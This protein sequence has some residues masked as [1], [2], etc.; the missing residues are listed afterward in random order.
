MKRDGANFPIIRVEKP[1]YGP[2]IINYCFVDREYGRQIAEDFIDEA[3]IKNIWLSVK[4]KNEG[5]AP[6]QV[7][8]SFFY[9]IDDGP[10]Q[11]IHELAGDLLN[12]GEVRE[13]WFQNWS[14]SRSEAADLCRGRY[15]ITAAVALEGKYDT[16]NSILQNS[17]KIRI[18][19]YFQLK[20]ISLNSDVMIRSKPID[21]GEI[22]LIK[23]GDTVTL[24]TKIKNMGGQFSLKR[25]LPVCWY[26][27]DDERKYKLIAKEEYEFTE[28]KPFNYGDEININL[29]LD[30]TNLGFTPYTA[31]GW[32]RHF[33][34]AIV[35]ADFENFLEEEKP[36]FSDKQETELRVAFDAWPPELQ[37]PKLAL[38]NAAPTEGQNVI[39]RCTFKNIGSGAVNL[40]NGTLKIEEFA[41]D[42][43]TVLKTHSPKIEFRETNFDIIP[44]DGGYSNE[45][46][47]CK[48]MS[49]DFSP[50][51]DMW[52]DS[53]QIK[54]KAGTFDNVC[55][56]KIGV[57][58]AGFTISTLDACDNATGFHFL[59]SPLL[60]EEGKTYHF[61][62]EG[63]TGIPMIETKDFRVGSRDIIKNGVIT[64]DSNRSL[65]AHPKVRLGCLN[66]L[67]VDALSQG[68]MGQIPL[69]PRQSE[70]LIEFDWDTTGR[71]ETKFIGWSFSS[72]SQNIEV[73]DAVPINIRAGK[74]K[75]FHFLCENPVKLMDRMRL[76]EF[77][78]KIMKDE[79]VQNIQI[80]VTAIIAKE[81]KKRFKVYFREKP[82]EGSTPVNELN[83]NLK[84][85]VP[86]EF[87]VGV[88]ASKKVAVGTIS[89]I[90]IEASAKA[91][92][93]KIEKNL[94]LQLRILS[95]FSEIFDIVCVD[96]RHELEG[97]T[98]TEYEVKL[99]NNSG[100][101]LP[102]NI[103]VISQPGKV[104]EWDYYFLPNRKREV[105]LELGKQPESFKLYAISMGSAEAPELRNVVIGRYNWDSLS[106]KDPDYIIEKQVNILSLVKTGPSP[107]V[108]EF[109]AFPNTA[110]PGIRTELTAQFT[111]LPSAEHATYNLSLNIEGNVEFITRPPLISQLER[112]ISKTV[113]WECKI[114]ENA[115]VGSTIPIKL[116]AKLAEDPRTVTSLIEIKVTNYQKDY[117]FALKTDYKLLP[118][119]PG[120]EAT[121]SITVEN[122][123]RKADEVSLFITRA[124]PIGGYLRPYKMNVSVSPNGMMTV[125]VTIFV[126]PNATSKDG[127]KITI[128]AVS[129]GNPTCVQ[130]EYVIAKIIGDESEGRDLRKAL[131]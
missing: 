27:D 20:P 49:F 57:I 45:G 123:G 78:I 96:N 116:T 43:S 52:I 59:K 16:K 36:L 76:L 121:L 108:M 25:K 113:T 99:Y 35:K 17:V 88:A 22:P 58:Y 93:Q 129:N 91:G 69:P 63:I 8:V 34:A 92:G 98:E 114:P 104:E 112:G 70:S 102:L 44:F 9:N 42:R 32:I 85:S 30:T 54:S 65:H 64:I 3:G 90:L 82:Q 122:T 68:R 48:M 81:D 124:L 100:R 21:K 41:A 5:L 101:P 97:I 84:D 6:A 12:P 86:K 62:L 109:K 103:S 89:S 56:S 61:I 38:S 19:P 117:N 127:G 15:G 2:E 73:A 39:C 37:N 7:H 106:S 105:S 29:T 115:V 55:C 131:F 40:R 4:V 75:G 95:D 110:D 11:S 71:T 77:P 47:A 51:S 128:K 66:T 79:D 94:Y 87:I 10:L 126:P 23:E 33:K 1:T 118:L 72:T 14:L 83:L 24:S 74:V 31:K 80:K 26:V 28:G 119:L 120:K 130:T 50:L 111:I 125:P 107:L 60:L 53:I 13:Y 46:T 67:P 18:P